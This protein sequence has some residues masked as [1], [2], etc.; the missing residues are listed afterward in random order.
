MRPSFLT[1]ALAVV[2]LAGCAATS[3]PPSS[4]TAHLRAS[5]QHPQRSNADRARDATRRPGDVLAF[6][7]IEPGDTVL[8][9]YSGGGYYTEIVSRAVGRG[10][11]VHAHNN[12]AYLTFADKEL[13][14]RFAKRRLKNVRRFTAENNALDLPANTYDK[15]LLILG[16]HDIYYIDEKNGWPRIDGPK[17]LAEIFRSL[18]SGG[19]LG[20]VDHAAVHG[21]PVD[22]GGTLHRIDPERAVR[23][24]TAAGFVLEARSDMLANANDERTLTMY[25][26]SVKS[27]TD[28]FVLRF[29]KP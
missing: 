26:P 10:G 19:V 23:E 11:V 6:F 22:V 15:A 21:A 27:K 28:R 1:S 17:M 3:A 9:L 5:L 4:G 14:A 16:Y 7:G 25:D 29:R 18:K 8:D 2:L 12:Q 24:I 13:Q 20:I